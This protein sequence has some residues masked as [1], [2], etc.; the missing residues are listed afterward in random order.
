MQLLQVK[1]LHLL[2]FFYTAAC[3]PIFIGL[4][5]QCQDPADTQYSCL[6]VSPVQADSY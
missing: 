6:P 3:K 2:F 5:V 1:I 4:G